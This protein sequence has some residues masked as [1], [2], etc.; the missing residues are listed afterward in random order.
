M[1]GRRCHRRHSKQAS[2]S[3][4]STG[5]SLPLSKQ[6]EEQAARHE[7]ALADEQGQSEGE[8]ANLE[9]LMPSPIAEVTRTGRLKSA[10]KGKI[11]I[12]SG[13]AE[14]VM[15]RDMLTSEPL[16]EGEGKKTGGEIW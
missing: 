10:G 4:S 8:V 12:D 11:T 14:S 6:A 13:A 15:P 9:V 3:S 16:L 2:S 1:S 5:T 7:R